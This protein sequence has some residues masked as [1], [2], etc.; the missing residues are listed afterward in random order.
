MFDVITFGSA[1]QDIFLRLNKKQVIVGKKFT[2]GKGV[3]FDLGSK[4][5]ADEIYFYCGGGGINTSATFA[6]QGLKTAYCGAIGKDL[7]GEEIIKD[8]NNRGVAVDF[9]KEKGK[10]TNHSIIFNLSQKDRT[11][12]A[13]RGASELL[14]RED[15][16]WDKMGSRWFYLAPLSGLACETSKS[17]I[18][19]AKE[20]EI[21]IAFNPG[22][23]QI[24]LPG[25]ILSEIL[26]KIDILILNQ[27]EASFLTKIPFIKEKE[28]FE[29]ID[30]MCPGIAIMTKGAKGVVASDGRYFYSANVLKTK[31]VDKTGAGDSFGAGFVSGFIKAN[32]DIGYAMQLGIA[33]S[34]SC[35]QQWGAKNGL[36]GEG[37]NWEKVKI[38]KL[39]YEKS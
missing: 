29:K 6:K 11:I 30:K 5:D 12:I 23:F 14:A 25:K 3:C 27:E 28:I 18:N 22:T 34:A 19:F 33:N 38:K 13:Y 24:S 4:V 9:V 15:I 16:P 7:A 37:D 39:K 17:I 20:K 31:V 36:L 1:A 21:K 10:P 32:G 35:L 2:A 8:L 26:S